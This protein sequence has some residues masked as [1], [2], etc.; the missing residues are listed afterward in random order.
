LYILSVVAIYVIGVINKSIK[1]DKYLNNIE[2]YN[3]NVPQ[4][5]ENRDPA[6]KN[7]YVTM[8]DGNGKSQQY[9][10]YHNS[11]EEQRLAAEALELQLQETAMLKDKK[12]SDDDQEKVGLKTKKCCVVQNLDKIKIEW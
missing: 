1:I 2:I 11:E 8:D 10:W 7:K 12:K 9:Y 4:R 5:R 3:M 6:R